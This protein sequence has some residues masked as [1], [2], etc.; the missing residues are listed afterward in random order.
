M[1]VRSWDTVKIIAWKDKGKQWKIA[2]VDKSNSRV[3]V[4]GVNI[5]T[6]HIKKQWATPGQIVKAEKSIHVSNVALIDS[7][8]NKTTKI[9]FKFEWEKK[10]RFAKK[11]W[12]IIK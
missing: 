7:T 9:G 5:V 2:A 8:T 12:K 6:R 4:E 11:S 10:V 3:L 1:K